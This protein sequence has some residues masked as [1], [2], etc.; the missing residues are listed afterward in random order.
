MTPSTLLTALRPLEGGPRLTVDL[1]IDDAPSMELWTQAVRDL[2]T[3]VDRAP[4]DGVR[5]HTVDSS[6]PGELR[7]D[8]TTPE[9]TPGHHA[10]LVFSDCVGPA[11]QDGRAVELLERRGRSCATAVLHA[12]PPPLRHRAAVPLAPFRWRA[13]RPGTPTAWLECLLQPGSL[14]AA[15]GLRAESAV[16]LLP[17]DD[18]D[19]VE[20][21]AR[22][23]ADPTSGWYDGE[24]IPSGAGTGVWADLAPPA[25]STKPAALIGTLEDLAG[26]VPVRLAALLA[27]SPLVTVDLLHAVRRDLLPEADGA[28]AA[29]AQVFYSGL[30]VRAPERDRDT[31][32]RRAHVLRDGVAELLTERLTRSD[33]RRALDLAGSI[34]PPAVWARGGA[35]LPTAAPARPRRRVRKDGPPLRARGVAPPRNQHFVGREGLLRTIRAA[36]VR[37]D[38]DGLC[39]LH[40]LAGVGKTTIAREYAH[41]YGD[42]YD[43]VWWCRAADDQSL[44]LSLD[45]LGQA[46]S[47]PG[48]RDGRG[49][50][51]AVLDRLHTGRVDRGWLLV[52]DNAGSPEKLFEYLPLDA[53]HILVTSRHI[54]WTER[55]EHP[56]HVEPLNRDE[57]R[58]LLRDSAD[59]LTDEQA[60]AV[61]GRAGNLPPLL[62]QLGRSLAQRRLSVADHLEGFDRLCAELLLR[63]GPADYD[64]RLAAGW[65]EAVAELGETDPAA[66]ELLRVLTCLGTG[67]VSFELLSAVTGPGPDAAG[68][69]GVLHDKIGLDLALRRLADEAL[70][71][72]DRDV[73]ET[74]PALH[75]VMRATVMGPNERAAAERSALALL[76]AALPKG[77]IDPADPAARARIAEL[78]HR[79]DLRTALR[80]PPET[81]GALVLAV[82]EHHAAVGDT[83]VAARQARAA[84]AVWSRSLGS[85]DPALLAFRAH[86]E[87]VPA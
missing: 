77:P 5:V 37:P 81:T 25:P 6:A 54:S 74:H 50:V 67:P 83:E 39:V 34:L 68:P 79:L 62:I 28:D 84:L 49:S 9:T 60:D 13:A 30:L 16:P 10:L 27:V 63:G 47:V 43:F 1:L 41:R 73:V 38:G 20:G 48:P 35:P 17:L 8:D 14:E 87:R 53:G 69:D 11:W 2:R 33:V 51:D 7:L 59:W 72:V 45:R 71:V 3:A 40:G 31:D 46:L 12:L 56:L 66:A 21:W 42:D 32:G 65:K 44:A 75:T 19:G 78:A 23:V 70:A 26:P 58:A 55:T 24:G 18:E 4:F 29:V 57:S 80:E 36:L 82:I 61:A 15:A 86:A 76:T 22:L 64:V 85:D 52:L